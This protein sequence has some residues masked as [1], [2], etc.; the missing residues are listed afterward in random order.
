MNILVTDNDFIAQSG[1]QYLTVRFNYNFLLELINGFDG[2]VSLMQFTAEL[3]DAKTNM[4]CVLCHT[5]LSI[6]TLSWFGF[7]PLAKILSYLFAIPSSISAISRSSLAYLFFPG[8]LSFIMA[9]ISIL[10]HHR[11]AL[12]LRGEKK[13][14]DTWLQRM[15]LRNASFILTVSPLLVDRIKPFNQR[16]IQIKPMMDINLNDIDVRN[17]YPMKAYWNFLYVGRVEERKGIGDLI[18]MADILKEYH[19]L[20]FMLTIIGGHDFRQYQSSL[21]DPQK[22]Y[23]TFTGVITDK[24]SLKHYYLDS[25]IFIFPT[26]DE[27][28]PRVLY[29]AMVYGT[30]IATTFVGGIPGFMKENHNCVRLPVKDPRGQAM[31]VLNLLKEPDQRRFLAINAQQDVSEFLHSEIRDHAAEVLYQVKRKLP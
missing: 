25:D 13:I 28:F 1:S 7:T 3:D 15:I 9:L 8:H 21:S 27:G 31:A 17:T 5:R 18:K 20:S 12:Y 26:H 2:T 22:T 4:Y 23:I 11:Y 30:P 29:E 24:A 16:T 10:L 14:T 6:I 19:Q